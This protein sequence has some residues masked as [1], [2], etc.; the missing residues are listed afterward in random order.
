MQEKGGETVKPEGGGGDP[1]FR[2]RIQA[3]CECNSAKER[4]L[5]FL[6][7][8]LAVFPIRLASRKNLE[9]KKLACLCIPFLFMILFLCRFLV[10]IYCIS[11]SFAPYI[12][13]IYI[14]KLSLQVTDF[15]IFV[16]SS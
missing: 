4:K 5:S 14:P 9:D 6:A 8:A 2:I 3:L 12:S 10:V 1:H 13:R 11:F 7:G 16:Y 15:I